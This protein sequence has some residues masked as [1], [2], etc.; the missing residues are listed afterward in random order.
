MEARGEAVKQGGPIRA[1]PHW[2]RSLPSHPPTGTSACPVGRFYCANR[3]HRPLTLNAS[4][5][6][7]GVCD[8]CDGS[9]EPAGAC[10]DTC[11]AS[12]AAALAAAEARL[13]AVRAGRAARAKA[14]AKARRERAAWARAVARADAEVAATQ[15]AVDAARPAKEA[16]DAEEEAERKTREK[17]EGGKEEGKEERKEEA[18]PEQDA[19]PPPPTDDADDPEAAGR[20]IAAQ[21]THD[22][23][24]AL[25]DE[26]PVEAAAADAAASAAGA[27]AAADVASHT[28]TARLLAWVRRGL[29][30]AKPHAP[31]SPRDAAR[32]VYAEAEAAA[33]AARDAREAAASRASA[34]LGPAAAFLPLHGACISATVDK[35]TYRVCPFDR[36]EQEDGSGGHPVSLGA[37]AGWGTASDASDDAP[38]PGDG[39]LPPTA[40]TTMRFADGAHCWNGPPRSLT[41]S[42][43]CGAKDELTGVAEPSRCEYVATL[44]TPA[45]CGETEEE[46]AAAEVEATRAVVAG[47]HDEL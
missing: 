25:G 46:A 6:D 23:D 24:A 43:V 45:A 5:V 3:G 10:R 28:L 31:E 19:P 27:A 34:D 12:G 20:R 8:C 33:S 16:A 1:R 9:D 29:A 38:P 7:D 42:V 21:W 2:K 47:A 13:E 11:A 22:K 15:A 30:A 37:W 35:Y 32:R 36:S 14:V 18:A 26:D 40:Y 17:E 4:S 44:A 41:V 39:A